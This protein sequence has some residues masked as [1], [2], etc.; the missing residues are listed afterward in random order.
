MANVDVEA[1]EL[2]SSE[3][4]EDVEKEKIGANRDNA[5]EEEDMVKKEDLNAE[6]SR[7]I[8]T[9]RARTIIYTSD[10]SDTSNLDALA[11]GDVASVSPMAPRQETP[12]TSQRTRQRRRGIR[13]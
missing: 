8:A 10:H 1:I 3:S 13:T 9:E 7:L 4:E 12:D 2:V 6:R 5:E 11:D